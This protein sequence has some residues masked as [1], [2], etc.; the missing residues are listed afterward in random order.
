MS[1]KK[2]TLE[3]DEKYVRR[4]ATVQWCSK[5]SFAAACKEWVKDN[6][7]T[8]TREE[9]LGLP[10]VKSG[11]RTIDTPRPD[12]VS[13]YTSFHNAE[14]RNLALVAPEYAAAVSE[15]L[16]YLRDYAPAYIKNAVS[17]RTLQDVHARS[18]WEDLG[19]G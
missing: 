17:V 10:W 15:V 14:Q 16:N 11:E 9:V 2:V 13:R 5:D 3:F 18:G 6:P 4:S 1:K 7:P 8:P 12:G 19:D